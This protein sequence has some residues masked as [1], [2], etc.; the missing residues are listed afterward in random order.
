MKN[1]GKKNGKIKIMVIWNFKYKMMN[2][3]SLVVE[4]KMKN[5]CKMIMNI[6][7]KIILVKLIMILIKLIILLN[8]K[9]IFAILIK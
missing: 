2:K 3:Q 7:N 9:M 4:Y 5:K 6:N 8:K 1:L